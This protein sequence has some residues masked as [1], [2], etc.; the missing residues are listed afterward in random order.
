MTVTTQ[1]QGMVFTEEQQAFAEAIRDFCKRECGTRDQRDALTDHGRES[2]NQDLHQ[3]IADLGWVG[4][5]V[6]EEYGGSGG[7]LVD[8]WQPRAARQVNDRK[9]QAMTTTMTPSAGMDAGS[10]SRFDL[11]DEQRDLREMTTKLA[12]ERHA[13]HVQQ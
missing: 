4:V 3:R 2:H 10:F 11:N 6:P 7:T 12:R 13:P 9:P 5:A 1:G 8:Q